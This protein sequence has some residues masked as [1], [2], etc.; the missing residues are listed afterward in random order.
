MTEKSEIVALLDFES[1]EIFEG[2][3]AYIGGIAFRRRSPAAHPTTP[4]RVVIVKSIE[5]YLITQRM[6]AATFSSAEIS[7]AFLSAFSADL[8]SGG[9]PWVLIPLEERDLRARLQSK[10]ERLDAIAGIFQG[11]RTGANDIYI[12]TIEDEA[13]ARFVRAINGVGEQLLLE[14]TYLRSMVYGS[15][16]KRYEIVSPTRYLIYPYKPNSPMSEEIL[17]Q[18]APLTY[19]YLKRYQGILSQR[20]GISDGSYKWFELVRRRNEDWLLKPKLLIRDLS[21][22]TAFAVDNTGVAFLVGG[23]AVVPNDL[24]CLLPLLAYL[25]TSIASNY[26]KV[27]TPQF[28]GNFQKFE[29]QHLEGLP[30]PSVLLEGDIAAKIGDLARRIVSIKSRKSNESVEELEIEIEKLIRSQI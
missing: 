4:T 19:K 20:S 13:D 9:A 26:L 7:D 1:L 15:D 5:S 17:A 23:T 22:E 6:L 3:S 29:P 16:V 25:N 30:V 18:E 11:I 2:T 28:R 21:P 8:P 24:G 14:R 10:S 12:V 27:V